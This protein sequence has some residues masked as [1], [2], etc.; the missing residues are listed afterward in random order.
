MSIETITHQMIQLLAMMALGFLLCKAGIVDRDFNKKL[1]G[2]LNNCALPATILA[3]VL[4]QTG[5]RDMEK[6]AVITIVS[7]AFYILMPVLSFLLVKP[8]PFIPEKEKGQYMFVLTFSNVGFMGIPVTQSLLGNEGVLY[9]AVLNVMFNVACFTLGVM[10]INY[11]NDGGKGSINLK[12]LLSPCVIASVAALMIYISGF[13]MPQ[14]VISICSTVGG[15]T[16]P[17]AMIMIGA[18][19]GTMKAGE[20]FGD[21]RVYPFSLFRQILLPYLIMSVIGLF[22][23]DAMMINVLSV[24]MLMPAANLAVILSYQYDR[25]E[26]LASRLVFISTLMSMI[27]IPV[28]L[29]FMQK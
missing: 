21:L 18:T 29:F 3:A 26:K 8:F 12:K 9:A 20:V 6:F 7:M 10:Q 25:D 17:A 22:I 23:K 13:R 1:T 16:T 27:T 2:L 5:E 14:D 24:M 11:G 19:L 28:M 4:D 15:I